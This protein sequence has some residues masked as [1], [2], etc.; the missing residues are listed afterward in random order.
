[1]LHSGAIREGKIIFHLA[2]HILMSAVCFAVLGVRAQAAEHLQGQRY[3]KT[4][5]VL[6]DR[7][8]PHERGG[9]Q[10]LRDIIGVFNFE[11]TDAPWSLKLVPVEVC[12]TRL[13]HLGLLSLASCSRR[14]TAS[15]IQ[16]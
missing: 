12:F 9:E 11:Q 4:L 3:R 8:V 5:S 15:Q 14:A 13:G 16:M 7:E 1:M 6:F 2:G 10:C